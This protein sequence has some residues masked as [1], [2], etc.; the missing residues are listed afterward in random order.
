MED[1]KAE[2]DFAEETFGNFMKLW[3]EKD[4]PGT[5]GWKYFQE[6]GNKKAS[7]KSN[8]Q[9]IFE[10]LLKLKYSSSK[11]EHSHWIDEI[12]AFIKEVRKDMYTDNSH[13][14]LD[15]NIY[16]D[17]KDSV[18]KCFEKGFAV[19]RRDMKTNTS[20]PDISSI[21]PNK[22]PISIE[23]ILVGDI[24]ILLDKLPELEG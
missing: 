8:L 14:K 22:S 24:D 17:I 10:H 6:S 11:L 21:I 23:E 18:D 15:R 12:Y 9:N 19:Y 13:K 16:N 7:I 2:L 4:F 3:L 5:E 1:L 20:L